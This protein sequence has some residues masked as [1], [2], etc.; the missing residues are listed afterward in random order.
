[1]RRARRCDAHHHHRFPPR[2]RGPPAVTAAP[3]SAKA[4][5]PTLQPASRAQA[6]GYNIKYY[7]GLGTSTSNEAKEYFSD[8]PQH[9]L[10][11]EWSGVTD[12]Q[13]IE[14]AFSKSMAD[15]RKDWLRQYD[16]LVHVD[17]SASHVTIARLE[18]STDER[19]K[20]SHPH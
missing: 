1:M 9:E 5:S 19:G 17:H 7:K 16:P 6:N 12:G 2:Y 11:F 13:L 4:A 10:T 18:R 14:R 20:P 15:A 8:L 3:R